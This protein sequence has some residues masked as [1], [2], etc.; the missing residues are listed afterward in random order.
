MIF[1]NRGDV[2]GESDTRIIEFH[3]ETQGIV[4]QYSGEGDAELETQFW[5]EQQLLPGGHILI[6][7]GSKGEI[8]EITRDG[9]IVWQ[10][11]LPHRNIV[12]G[13]Q[14]IAVVTHAEKLPRAQIDF[15][16]TEE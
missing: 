9:E 7:H 15:E 8:R 4:W 3:P 1:D 14:H 5:G 2:A 13:E 12:K 10:Y 11:F 16:L 6:T